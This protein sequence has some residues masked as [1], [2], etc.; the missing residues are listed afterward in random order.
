MEHAECWTCC[1]G[2]WDEPGC[3]EGN[4]N[5]ILAKD[6]LKLC[7]NNGEPNPN[8]GKPD[9][10]CGK[11]YSDKSPDGCKYHSGY[12]EKGKWTCCSNDASASGCVEG[13]HATKIIQM[14]KQNYISILNIYLILDLNMRKK[15]VFKMSQQQIQKN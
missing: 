1:E 12:I 4:H 13:S 6:R 11:W 7:L 14:K 15:K 3:K 10:L 2:K 5:G 8:N 9:N